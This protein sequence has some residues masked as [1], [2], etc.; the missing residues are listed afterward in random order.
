MGFRGGCHEKENEFYGFF[1]LS[2]KATAFMG[3]MMFGQF[4]SWFGSMRAGIATVLI[5]F[6]IG[7]LLMLRVDEKEGINL[8]RRST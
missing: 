3:P 1:A 5:F 4:T 2:G 8:A 6:V 7:G